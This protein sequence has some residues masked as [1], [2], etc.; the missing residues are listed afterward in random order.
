MAT[1]RMLVN[2]GSRLHGNERVA[3][4]A[5]L[6][7]VLLFLPLIGE[8]QQ[9]TTT[10][11]T[12]MPNPA[13][14][15]EVVTLTAT[16]LSGSSPVTVGTVTFLNGMQV[17]GT[18]Q[19]VKSGQSSGTATLKLGFPPGTYQLTAQYNANKLFQGSQSGPQPLTVTGTEPTITTLTDQPD[20]NNWDFTASVFG[21]GFPGLPG[22]T[23][24]ASFTDLTTLVNLGS[25][26]LVGPGMSTF[27]PQQTYPAGNA[28]FGVAIGDFNG[29]GIADLAITNCSDNFRCKSFSPGTVSV[30]L[31]NRDGSFQPPVAYE[32][33]GGPLFVAVGDFNGDGIADLA[34]TNSTD[35]AATVSVLLGNGD[36]TFQSQQTYATGFFPL[37]IAVGD[38]NG[39]GFAD[40]A[41][42]NLANGNVSVL[43][44]DGDGTFQPQQTY[45]V[46]STPEGIAVGDFN[47][48]GFADLAVTNNGDSTVSVLLGKGDGTFQNQQTYATGN[49]PSSVAVADFNG[50]GFADLAV[51]NQNDATVSVL[52]GKGNGTFQ[53]QQ[54]YGV[55]SNPKEIAVADF[56]GDGF[57]DL[58]ITN[59][60]D[61]TVSVLLGNGDGTFQPQQTYTV[62]LFPYGIAVADFNG[63]GVPDVA[64]ANSEDNTTSILLGGTVTGGQLKNIPVSGNGVHMIQSAYTPNQHFYTDSLSKPLNVN[65]NGS[66]IPT[67]TTVTSSQNPSQLNQ[68]VTFTALVTGN[69]DGMPTGTV[70]F[71]SDG[72]PI[73]ECPNPVNLVNGQATC[74]TST[75]P[76][77]MHAIL[78]VYSGDANFATSNGG[79]NQ[80]VASAAATSTSLDVSPNPASAGQVVTLTATVLSGSSPVTVGTVTFLSGS[81]VL[82]TVQVIENGGSSGTATLHLGFPPGTYQLTA[83]Y[84]AN[85]LFQAS[86]SGQQP[87]TVNG[88]E[89]TIT[90]VQAA[91]DGSNYDFT[92]SAFGY[93]F[94][95]PTGMASLTEMSSGFNLGNIGLPGPGM[96]TFA[97][98]GVLK[99]GNSPRGGVAAGDFNADGC[100]DLVVGNQ[101]DNTVSVLLGNCNGTFQTQATYKVDK[102]PE[103]IAVGDFNA[104]GKLDLAVACHDSNAI[105]VLLG[106]GDG[107][108]QAA[109]PYP[110]D[111]AVAVAVGDFNG[112]GLPDLAS[113]SASGTAGV[114][115][116][117]G[118]GTFTQQQTFPAGSEPS[119]IA[120]G[121]FNGDGLLDLAVAA[122][123]SNEVFVLLGDGTGLF[124]STKPYAVGNNPQAIATGDFN[125]DGCLDLAVANYTDSTVSVLVGHITSGQCDGTFS[126]QKT[127]ATGLGPQGIAVA[128]FN[129]DRILDL[130]VT[131]SAGNTVGVL[132]G[133]GDG[134]FQTQVTYPVGSNPIQIAVADFLGDGVPDVAVANALDNTVSV[135]LGGTLT[136]GQL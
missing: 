16:V 68:P 121:D 44:G 43:L 133:K 25:V 78:G 95:T 97:P 59:N 62:G 116:N 20:G 36:G 102:V 104:D 8:A 91:P 61:S 83:Q 130:A 49:G 136:P 90:T 66:L 79:L 2:P 118:D 29:D 12:V 81:Q 13:S 5:A 21:F 17:L 76:L 67:T 39:D 65:G 93:G 24:T 129:G 38:F 47:G 94:A 1:P 71:T 101:N 41:I 112:D 115:L 56:N 6:L 22:P 86:Q 98:Q 84:N 100:P 37:Q 63:D 14:A 26:G 18:I 131:N 109:V 60:S 27:Q 15:G 125:G 88:T 124:S 80:V 135:L 3:A 42:T 117:N 28:P 45:A 31:G 10:S 64:T 119:A 132:L 23:G 51:T 122:S 82:G 113:A 128:D 40:L 33:G 72:N 96:S 52:L 108:F 57:A 126:A 89:P 111:T 85:N 4:A 114:L 7:L 50:D 53:P 92:V 77:G 9:P 46:G 58:A 106:I 99:V 19:M 134:T 30:L 87:L 103:E 110:T 11:L 69:G 75:L 70:T 34:V 107:T 123:G 74:T 105:D 32:V 120:V 55:G 35:L 73:S 127:Y 48:D 54:A